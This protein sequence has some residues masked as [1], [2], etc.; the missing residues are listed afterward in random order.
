[1]ESVDDAFSIEAF[2]ASVGGNQISTS[3][4]II[5]ELQ[6]TLPSQKQVDILEELL[7]R[8]WLTRYLFFFLI[9]CASSFSIL[10]RILLRNKSLE[11]T[12]KLVAW[13]E[14]AF[15]GQ[16]SDRTTPLP[17]AIKGYFH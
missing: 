11:L 14:D 4:L 8:D 16:R 12:L 3:D 1:M 2:R 13:C 9:L 17:R 10:I 5:N 7:E 6:K 15:A